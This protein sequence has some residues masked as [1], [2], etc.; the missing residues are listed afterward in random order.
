MAGREIEISERDR[1]ILTHLSNQ[2][3]YNRDI[4]IRLDQKAQ[5]LVTVLI[6]IT[7]IYI[8]GHLLLFAD[9]KSKDNMGLFIIAFTFVFSLS[10][11]RF[12][13]SIAPAIQSAGLIDPTWDSISDWRF[14]IPTDEFLNQLYSQYESEIKHTKTVAADKSSSLKWLYLLMGGALGTIILEALWYIRT[15]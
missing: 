12:S 14:H 7:S 8:T 9:G 13:R 10:I 1:I 4:C 2:Y 15:V 6:G 11:W 3:N 5:H